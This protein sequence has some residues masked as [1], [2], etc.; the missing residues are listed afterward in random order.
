MPQPG[1]ERKKLSLAARF[2]DTE[3]AP[4]G[5]AFAHITLLSEP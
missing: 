4:H 2:C 3:A 5:N 1:R